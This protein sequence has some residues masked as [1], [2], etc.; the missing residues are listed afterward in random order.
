MI[1]CHGALPKTPFLP[2]LPK[3]K[4]NG[5]VGCTAQHCRYAINKL[6]WHA[7]KYYSDHLVELGSCLSVTVRVLLWRRTLAWVERPHSEPQNHLWTQQGTCVQQ[8]VAHQCLG[9][10]QSVCSSLTTCATGPAATRG[11]AVSYSE[12]AKADAGPPDTMLAVG[13]PRTQHC[14]TGSCSA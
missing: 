2:V 3:F 10:S 9:V 5:V 13:R 7:V 1:Q 12:E 6:R 14:G 4:S 8:L 11:R